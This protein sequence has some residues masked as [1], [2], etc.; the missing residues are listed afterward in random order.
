MKLRYR[1][2]KPFKRYPDNDNKQKFNRLKHLVKLNI[3]KDTRNEM[4][5]RI[6]EDGLLE[7]SFEKTQCMYVATPTVLSKLEDFQIEMNGEPIKKSKVFKIPRNC[8]LRR[9]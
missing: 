4:E 3:T 2:Y 1:A 7:L 6:T 9:L 8:D 5:L